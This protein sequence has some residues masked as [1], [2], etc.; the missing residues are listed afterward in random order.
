[1]DVYEIFG[2]KE[3]PW[4]GPKIGNE[5]KLSPRI[6]IQPQIMGKLKKVSKNHHFLWDFHNFIGLYL[7]DFPQ[8]P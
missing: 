1:M 6:S 3:I 2:G 4:E 5:L 7:L 8:A